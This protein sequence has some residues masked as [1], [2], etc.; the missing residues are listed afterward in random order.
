MKKSSFHKLYLIDKDMYD[1]IM[2]HLN[3][4][5]KQEIDDLNME[6][7]PEYDNTDEPAVTENFKDS[8]APAEMHLTEDNIPPPPAEGLPIV[9]A[10]KTK[11]SEG[12]KP[13]KEKKFSCTECIKKFTTKSSLKRHQNKFHVEKQPINNQPP[14]EVKTIP[15]SK[16]YKRAREEDSD[17]IDRENKLQH[18]D[19]T[20]SD[21]LPR[22]GV[23][24]KTYVKRYSDI[25]PRKKLRLWESY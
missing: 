16:S 13:M 12:R 22:R 3:Q 25:E 17:D 19:E 23:K 4:V 7:R 14:V 9:T 24:R 21:N 18:V 11:P 8:S 1:R 6:H 2:P 15:V 5:E 10:A 20:E